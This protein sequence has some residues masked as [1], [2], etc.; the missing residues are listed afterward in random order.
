MAFALIGDIV[1][2][3]SLEERKMVQ[4]KLETLIEKLNDDYQDKMIKKLAPTL[5][6]EFQALFKDGTYILEI[7]NKIELEMY[8][9]MLRFGVGI[10]NVDFDRGNLNSP[11]G[12][13]GP[14]W[15]N[16]R[17][18]I[19]EVKERKSKNKLEHFSNI[20]IRSNDEFFNDSIDPVLDICYAIKTKWTDKQR[21]LIKLTIDHYGFFSKFNYNYPME[22]LGQS[23][24]TIYGKYQSS[25]YANYVSV[26]KSITK[27]LIMEGKKDDI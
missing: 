23:L 24:S 21:E 11:F 19:D 14:V 8:P 4:E 13:D 27:T 12:S 9:T 5:G 25:C 20:Y 22:V 2:S 16:A 7:I 18:A 3:K 15:W 6:D 17:K 26:M 10:G 1:S